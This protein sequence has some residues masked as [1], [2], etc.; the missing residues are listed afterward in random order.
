MSSRQSSLSFDF[1]D[2][3]AVLGGLSDWEDWL[4]RLRYEGKAWFSNN[5]WSARARFLDFQKKLHAHFHLE[6]RVIFPFFCRHIPRMSECVVFFASEHREIMVHLHGVKDKMRSLEMNPPRG[7]PG[8]ETLKLAEIGVYLA[9][10]V[11]H[12]L[13]AE[14]KLFQEAWRE[15]RPSERNLLLRN[16]KVEKGG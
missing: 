8:Q 4:W 16:L 9:C 10:L 2:D 3:Q 6:E 13:Q 11:K 5:L 12:H 7:T 15:L 14:N 1:C